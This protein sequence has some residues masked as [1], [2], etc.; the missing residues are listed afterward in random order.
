[1]PHIFVVAFVEGTGYVF[2]EV[3]QRAALRQIVPAPQLPG[4]I[5]QIQGREYGALLV[6]QP[7]GGVLFGIGRV[8]PFFVDAISYLASTLSLLLIRTRLQEERQ[9]T[10]QHLLRDIAEGFAYLWRQP[11]LRTTSLLVTGSDL[12]INTLYL[13]IIVVA[14]ER[15]ASPALIGA[16]FAFIGVGGIAGALVAPLAARLLKPRAVVVGALL[17]VTVLLPLMTVVPGAI[18]LGVLYGAMFVALPAWNSVIGAYRIALVPDRL[19]GRVE[20]VATLL[21]LGAVPVGA[22]IVGILLEAIGSTTTILILFGLMVIVLLCAIGS[23]AVR[24]APLLD[25]VEAVA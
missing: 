7:L 9:E 2:F 13:V 15:G 14:K 10:R 3:A 19:Q 6:G 17:I 8:V 5:A 21:A 23:R 18:P 4:A 24:D 1:M 11:L 12:V 25:Q 16:M 22:L 20:S